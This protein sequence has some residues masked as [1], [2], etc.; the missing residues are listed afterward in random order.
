MCICVQMIFAYIYRVLLTKYIVNEGK[1]LRR[2]RTITNRKCMYGGIF[3]QYDSKFPATYTCAHSMTPNSSVMYTCAHSGQPIPRMTYKPDEIST[4]C[5]KTTSYQITLTSSFTHLLPCSLP[6]LLSL[7]GGQYFVSW[8]N[9]TQP[10]PARSTMKPFHS[11]KRNVDTSTAYTFY[12]LP[13]RFACIFS[14]CPTVHVNGILCYTH[15]LQW[16]QH[17]TVAVC[18][19]FPQRAHWIPTQACSW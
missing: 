3:L 2:L 17:S 10:M 9:S 13:L 4:W 12:I 1:T 8:P 15:T 7:V 11:W 18:V 19:G 5:V 16:A 14:M 6:T